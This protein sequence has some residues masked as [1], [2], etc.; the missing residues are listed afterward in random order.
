MTHRVEN[1]YP[2]DGASSNLEALCRQRRDNARPRHSGESLHTDT[3][4]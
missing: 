1:G 3:Q 4:G 2:D